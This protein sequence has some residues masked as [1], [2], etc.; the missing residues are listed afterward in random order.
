MEVSRNYSEMASERQSQ[1]DQIEE[2]SQNIITG[3]EQEAG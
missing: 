1:T 2:T 3:W